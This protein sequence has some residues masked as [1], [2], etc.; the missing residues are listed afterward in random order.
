M[1]ITP[2]HPVFQLSKALRMGL[3]QIQMSKLTVLGIPYC[4]IPNRK[5]IT[6]VELSQI[7]QGLYDFGQT[8][9]P[10]KS[11]TE[12]LSDLKYGLAQLL[13]L[14]TTDV[15]NYTRI[16]YL[17]EMTTFRQLCVQN[18]SPLFTHSLTTQSIFTTI[19]VENLT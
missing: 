6:R 4:N 11:I 16:G 5:L 1:L 17:S 3:F 10:K 15:M 7:Y 2:F 9:R 8:Y 18:A 13:H 12:L 14:M 19:S